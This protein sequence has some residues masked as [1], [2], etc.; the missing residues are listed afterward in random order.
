DIERALDRFL[1]SRARV[2]SGKNTVNAAICLNRLGRY[3]EALEMFEE[4][5]T[6]HMADL[7]EADRATIAPAMQALRQKVGTL[8]ISVDVEG[9]AVHVDS[10]ARG[11]LPLAVP[12]RVNAGIHRIRVIKEGYE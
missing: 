9:A 5:V 2:P 4:V 10:R 3:D 11:R 7:R 8:E 6:K 12:L 1:R